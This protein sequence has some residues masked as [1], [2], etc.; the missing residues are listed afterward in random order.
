M[1]KISITILGVDNLQNKGKRT[2]F[3]EMVFERPELA[4]K[5]VDWL[6]HYVDGKSEELPNLRKVAY[7]LL[8]H[9]LDELVKKEEKV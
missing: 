3:E 1:T 8:E 2:F 9:A 7:D 4:Q 6:W 5:L